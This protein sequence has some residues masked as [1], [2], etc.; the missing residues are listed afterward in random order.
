M[1]LVSSLKSVTP[2]SRYRATPRKCGA[3]HGFGLSRS[4]NEPRQWQGNL[5]FKVRRRLNERLLK[6][7]LVVTMPPVTVRRNAASTRFPSST[8][9]PVMEES[10]LSGK[11]SIFAAACWGV[12]M[13]PERRFQNDPSEVRKMIQAIREERFK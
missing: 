6:V 7:V 11:L 8:R 9:F 4:L 10:C 13:K 1:Q 12:G 5:G 3:G 2:V